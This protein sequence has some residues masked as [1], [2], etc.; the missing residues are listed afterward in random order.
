MLMAPEPQSRNEMTQSVPTRR[1]RASLVALATLALTSMIAA[2][3]V[4]S[5]MAQ[6]APEP[7]LTWAPLVTL[8]PIAPPTVVSPA[9][10]AS[11]YTLG[12][13]DAPVAIEVWEDFQ[14]PFCRVFSEQVKPYLVET[15]VEPGK[16]SLTF[17]HLAFLGEESHWAAVAADLAAEQDLFWPFHD[18]LFA[19]Q[20]GE[21]RGSYELD[22]LL[23]MAEAAGLD[24]TAFRAGLVLDAARER[25][26]RIDAESRQDAGALGIN[27]TPSLVLDGEL[28]RFDSF[29]Q[30]IAAIDEA[31]AAAEGAEVEATEAPSEAEPGA[32]APDA[33]EPEPAAS[34]AG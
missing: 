11:G 6:E 20:L 34:P 30:A 29:D 19:N 28:L 27:G 31:V 12:D 17:R 14:C 22:R 9:E 4:G 10:L 3:G 32:T 21:N 13:P 33:E 18:Y 25:F 1:R 7:Q 16:A 26:A 2:G 5:A 8:P 23:A 24:M 15:Y